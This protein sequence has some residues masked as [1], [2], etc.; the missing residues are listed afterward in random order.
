MSTLHIDRFIIETED[1]PAIWDVRCNEYTDS[2]A[3]V[4]AWEDMCDIFGSGYREMHSLGPEA[5][6]G[7]D[8]P[9]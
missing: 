9:Q 7:T 3:K 8:V 4:K 5:S 6:T 1:R 2:I